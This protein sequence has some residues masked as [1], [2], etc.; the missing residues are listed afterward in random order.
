MLIVSKLLL[1]KRGGVTIVEEID[2][3]VFSIIELQTKLEQDKSSS[4]IAKL[5]E[6]STSLR[7]IISPLC[8]SI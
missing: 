2:E 5:Q 6:L 1:I 3:L 4:S 7:I 8:Q